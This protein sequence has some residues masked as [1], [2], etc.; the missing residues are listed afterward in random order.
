MKEG[1]RVLFHFLNASATENIQL[2][3]P[4][5]EFRVVALDGNPVP[6]PKNVEVVELDTAERISA[7][8][9]MKNPG[10]WVLGT[11]KD[12]D[13]KNGMGIVVEYANKTGSPRWVKPR[14]KPWDYTLFGAARTIANPDETIPLVFGKINGGKG[15]FNRWTIN[16]SSFAEGAQPRTLQTSQRYRL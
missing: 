2:A 16:A 6:Q 14:K 1:Q 3:L 5:H 9:E 7:V 15:G 13:R 10:V 11:P 4:G 12:E 8:V